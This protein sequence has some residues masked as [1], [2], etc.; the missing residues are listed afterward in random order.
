MVRNRTDRIHLLFWAAVA[1]K[2]VEGRR[3][4]CVDNTWPA[5]MQHTSDGVVH[6]ESVGE[7]SDFGISMIF[8]FVVV[9]G[10]DG[11]VEDL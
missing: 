9:G 2:L 7:G 5:G 6:T 4:L 1:A 11:L 8:G 3:S 10:A